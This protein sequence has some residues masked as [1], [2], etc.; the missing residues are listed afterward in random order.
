MVLWVKSVFSSGW[1]FF[2]YMVVERNK[3]GPEYGGGGT[4]CELLEVGRG[5]FPANGSR[6]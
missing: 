4:E 1:G 5:W 3:G 6:K 2:P